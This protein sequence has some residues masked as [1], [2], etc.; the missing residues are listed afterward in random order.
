MP[1]F[2]YIL[3]SQKNNDIYIGSCENVLIRLNR[4]NTGKVKS[5]KGYKPWDLLESKQFNTR[6]EAVKQER[7]LKSHQQKEI[8]KRK[9]KVM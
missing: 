6:G 1:Y 9:Y 4:H 3:K 8:I 5:T 7:F 2:T